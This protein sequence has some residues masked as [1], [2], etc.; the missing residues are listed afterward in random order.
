M[1]IHFASAA[2][3]WAFVTRADHFSDITSATATDAFFKIT[4]VVRASMLEMFAFG[5]GNMAAL[6]TSPIHSYHLL[7]NEVTSRKFY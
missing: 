6:W 3:R 2:T 7:I 1:S 5:R 4:V